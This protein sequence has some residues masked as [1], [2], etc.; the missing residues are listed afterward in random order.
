MSAPESEQCLINNSSTQTKRMPRH[1]AES[2]SSSHVVTPLRLHCQFWPVAE[3]FKGIH[4][5]LRKGKRRGSGGGAP[6]AVNRAFLNDPRGGGGQATG[7]KKKVLTCSQPT[8]GPYPLP[9]G[10]VVPSAF[11]NPLAVGPPFLLPG[12]RAR[13]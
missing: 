13:S 9:P 11:R 8:A 10:G 5:S 6:S 4:H 7:G 2:S 3:Q 12:A 1:L